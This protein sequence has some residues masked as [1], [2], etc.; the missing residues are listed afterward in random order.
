MNLAVFGDS[1][2]VGTELKQ[3]ELPF[4]E[5]LHKKLGTVNYYNQAQQGSTV[6]SLILQLDR[7]TT[8]NIQDCICVFFITNPTR[9]LYFENGKEKVLR[10]TGDKSHLTKFYFGEV[11]SN[12]LDYHKANISILALQKMCDH[13]AYE[14]YYIE[15]WTNID[16]KYAGIDKSKILPQSATEMFGAETNTKTLELAKFQSN[17]YISPNKYHPN[18]KGHELIAENLYNFIK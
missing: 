18:Q 7:F 4:G 10:P 1:W 5:L 13:F 14:D 15:G 16:W 8:Q 2:P 17:T 3:G 6:D 11:Q 12:E 9:Y